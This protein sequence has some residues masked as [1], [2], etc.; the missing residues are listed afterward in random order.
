MDIAPTIT[1][2]ITGEELLALGDIGPCELIDGRIFYMS[3]TNV[4]HAIIEFLLGGELTQ[5]VQKRKLGRVIGGEVGIYT[6][7]NPD[8]IRGADIAFVSLERM[9]SK[10]PKGFLTTAPELV[11]EVMSPDDRWQD[12]ND[13]IEE[14]FSIGVQQVWIVEPDNRAVRIYRSATEMQ[15]LSESDVLKGEGPLTGFE[16]PVAKLFES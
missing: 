10:P 5:F 16:M 15:K 6:R 1:K 9:P 4:E 7:R 8:R 12:V 2:L 3:P 14:Y 11:V 13:K